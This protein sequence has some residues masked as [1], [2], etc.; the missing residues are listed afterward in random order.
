MHKNVYLPCHLFTNIWPESHSNFSHSQ[1]NSSVKYSYITSQLLQISK[2]ICPNSSAEI[3]SNS[4]KDT[5]IVIKTKK[6]ANYLLVVLHDYVQLGTNT[7]VNQLW[8][9]KNV[10]NITQH[11]CICYVQS[12]NLC[13]F[14]IELL[15][16]GIPKMSADPGIDWIAC[17][18]Q[19]CTVRKVGMLLIGGILHYS[20]CSTTHSSTVAVI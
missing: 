5:D 17:T 7:L 10:L 13:D 8:K 14:E 20:H 11:T 16:V 15:K 6:C 1:D 19:I 4:K 3:T 2:S 9:S 18:F 12:R